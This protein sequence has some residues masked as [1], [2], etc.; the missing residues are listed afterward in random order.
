MTYAILIVNNNSHMI[1]QHFLD[2]KISSAKQK[3]KILGIV[4]LVLLVAKLYVFVSN[5]FFISGFVAV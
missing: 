5:V 2:W 4:F 3:E 1:I